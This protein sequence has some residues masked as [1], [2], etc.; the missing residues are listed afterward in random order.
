MGQNIKEEGYTL[1]EIKTDN[2]LL[3]LAKWRL[4]SNFVRT[5][6]LTGEVHESWFGKSSSLLREE[7]WQKGYR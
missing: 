3:K 4:L 7:E 2:R 5:M 6:T 1:T